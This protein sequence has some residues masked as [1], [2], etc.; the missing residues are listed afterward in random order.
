MLVPCIGDV[1]VFDSGSLLKVGKIKELIPSAD[2]EI[3]KVKVESEGHESVHAVANLRRLESGGHSD[4][5]S[6]TNCEED[7]S[8]QHDN[9]LPKTSGSTLGKLPR[10][11]PKRSAAVKAQQKWLSQFLVTEGSCSC[12]QR[13]VCVE[14][15]GRKQWC[16]HLN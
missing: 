8:E 9:D 15:A 12:K 13:F 10:N 6:P 7:I 11:N 4:Q 14:C 16:T 5:I 3:R 1:V 2:K